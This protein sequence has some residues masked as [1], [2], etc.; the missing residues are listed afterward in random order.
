M[1]DAKYPDV[2]YFKQ[3]VS[4]KIVAQLTT[5]HWTS[6]GQLSVDM[7]RHVDIDTTLIYCVTFQRKKSISSF[8]IREIASVE[9]LHDENNR[10]KS[11]FLNCYSLH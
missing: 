7:T 1:F 3:N 8:D 11:Y 9:L 6:G 2:D 5:Q 10:R 4:V